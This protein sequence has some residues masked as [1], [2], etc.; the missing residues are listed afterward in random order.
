MTSNAVDR[1]SADIESWSEERDRQ[2]NHLHPVHFPK[3]FPFWYLCLPGLFHKHT[4]KCLI[5]HNE[6]CLDGYLGLAH[7]LVSNLTFIVLIGNWE[8]KPSR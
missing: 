6:H 8:A 3:T 2:V 7:V 4:R 5:Y 1:A